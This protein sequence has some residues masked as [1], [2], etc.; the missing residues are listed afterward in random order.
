MHLGGFYWPVCAA[1]L[2]LEIE[3]VKGLLAWADTIF[4][5]SNFQ[6]PIPSS[7]ATEL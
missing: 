4:E 1:V 2:Q 7:N 5:T 3:E 6:P